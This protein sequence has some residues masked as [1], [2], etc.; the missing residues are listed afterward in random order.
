MASV[1]FYGA[2]KYKVN[3]L[4][5]SSYLN[6]EMICSLVFITEG[7][8]GKKGEMKV[9]SEILKYDGISLFYSPSAI[10]YEQDYCWQW[11]DNENE[12]EV[13]V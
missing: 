11:I 9:W 4:R 7:R 5:F 13:V 2:V 12:H 6:Q 8:Y 1:N 10:C 3:S